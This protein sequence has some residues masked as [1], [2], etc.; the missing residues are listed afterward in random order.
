M[1][2]DLVKRAMGNIYDLVSR[3]LLILHLYKME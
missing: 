3:L 1:T 2:G